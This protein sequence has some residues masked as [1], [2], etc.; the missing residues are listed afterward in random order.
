MQVDRLV[1]VMVVFRCGSSSLE[2][3]C[4]FARGSGVL[5]CNGAQEWHARIHDRGARVV[6]YATRAA[7]IRL[8]VVGVSYRLL[9]IVYLQFKQCSPTIFWNHHRLHF[10]R[11]ECSKCMLLK[12]SCVRACVRAR[13]SVCARALV[14]VCLCGLR[15]C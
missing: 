15:I 3:E 14:C 1:F 11:H 9:S 5:A 7:R 13:V 12:C 10:G 2:I 6:F 8:V 4:L